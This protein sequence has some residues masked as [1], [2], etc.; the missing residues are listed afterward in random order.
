MINSMPL[1]P[2]TA[3][4][5]FG[6]IAAK[7]EPPPSRRVGECGWH[8]VANVTPESLLESLG[9]S[10][11]PGFSSLVQSD[12]FAAIAAQTGIEPRRFRFP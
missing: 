8:E 4:A 2:K 11:F 5:R 3:L 7:R 10:H 6:S 9:T 12:G 1:Q